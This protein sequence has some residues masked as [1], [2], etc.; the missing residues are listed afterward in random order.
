MGL[1]T[2]IRQFLF[3]ESG[4][5]DFNVSCTLY[6]EQTALCHPNLIIDEFSDE[7]SSMK[8]DSD[9][10]GEVPGC[11]MTALR[12]VGLEVVGGLVAGYISWRLVKNLYVR[13]RVRR[14]RQENR[15]MLEAQTGR[16]SQ[17][18]EQCGLSTD[19][20]KEITDLPW[21][22]LVSRLQSGEMKAVAALRAYQAAGLEVAGRTNCVTVW[23]EEAVREAKRLDSLPA[24]SRGPLHGVP[25]SVKECYEVAGTFA[26]AGMTVFAR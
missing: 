16:L 8:V 12:T 17:E 1:K 14:I 5:Q 6:A 20:L 22:E 13:L 26:T 9:I 24:D 3:C 19:Q 23:L 4:T 25:V 7:F 2:L 21:T 11:V 18:V 10:V 15:E